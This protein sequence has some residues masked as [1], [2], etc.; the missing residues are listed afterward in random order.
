MRLCITYI[1]PKAGTFDGLL[2]ASWWTFR[3]HNSW[4][5]LTGQMTVQDLGLRCSVVEAFTRVA[6]CEVYIGIHL[7]MLWDN[8]WPHLQGSSSPRRLNCLGLED[9]TDRLSQNVNKQLP[10]YAAWHARRVKASCYLCL[11]KGSTVWS[12]YIGSFVSLLR[13]SHLYRE[14]CVILFI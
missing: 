12:W 5:F 8:I 9:G 11:T 10:S 6:C 4:V 13:N 2:W 14:F 7:L 1:W 3:F